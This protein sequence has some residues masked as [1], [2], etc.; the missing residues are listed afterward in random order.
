MHHVHELPRLSELTTA[1]CPVGRRRGDRRRPDAP[2]VQLA[3]TSAVDRWADD[4]GARGHRLPHRGRRARRVDLRAAAGRVVQARRGVRG[5]GAAARRSHRRHPHEAARV[6]PDGAGGM[7]LGDGV[8]ADVH[9]S[10]DRRPGPP[11]PRR[12]PDARWSSTP[13]SATP[14]G[15]RRSSSSTRRRCG[16]NAPRG[17]AAPGRR[18]LLGRARQA[19]RARV[20]TVHTQP[21]DPATIMFTSGT[22]G[23]PKGCTIPHGAHPRAAP[24][25]ALRP[26]IC[27]D[28]DVALLPAPTP[29]GP[30]ACTPWASPPSPWGTPIVVA[31]GNFDPEKWLADHDARRRS[32]SWASRRARCAASSP[33]PPRP[34]RPAADDPPRDLRRR[35]ARRGPAPRGVEDA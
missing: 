10:R 20:A 25:R 7:A 32:P 27:G 34:V 9:R 28:D 21:T 8:R 19:A 30:T 3:R 22:T 15:R 18:G 26:A 16:A 24:L 5:R 6:L 35:A 12:R 17:R 2:L 33:S 4:A 11:R 29:A 13:P 14:G 1:D 23:L 31:R